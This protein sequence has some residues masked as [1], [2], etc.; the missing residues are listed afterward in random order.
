MDSFIYD[1]VKKNQKQ[2]T[3]DE[4][5]ECAFEIRRSCDRIL[6]VCYLHDQSREIILD[7]LD[8]TTNLSKL[9]RDY[10]S[11]ILGHNKSVHDRI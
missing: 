10:N 8:R 4:Q 6:E 11:A 1:L 5:Y 3:G 9:G 2:L 7:T